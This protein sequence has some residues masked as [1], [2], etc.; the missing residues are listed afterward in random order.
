MESTCPG[1]AVLDR[2]GRD[3]RTKGHW[4]GWGQ[5]SSGKPGGN[6]QL[7]R[8][9]GQQARGPANPERPEAPTGP[10]VEDQ[11]ATLIQCAFRQHLARKELARRQLKRQEY[12]EQMEK[13]QREAYLASVRHEQEVARRRR[14][15]EEAAQRERLEELQ[16]RRRLLDAAFDGDLAEIRA[17]LNEVEQ[18]L[19][20]DGVGHDEAGRS[21]RLQRR[22]AMVECEDSHGN[23]PLSEAAAGGQ[24]LA[25]QLLAELGA[26][27]NSK[28]ASLN[29]VASVLQSWD[30]S[31]TE[32]MLQNMEAE[33]QRR[34]Q[35]AQQQQAAEAKRLALKVQ[36]LARE[37]QQCH[38]V[39]QQAYCELHRRISEHDR[40][41]QKCPD[42][43]ELTLQ[44]IKDTETHVDKL[45][46]EAQ[47]AEEM[48]AMARLEL[49]E[50]SKEEEEEAPGL[51]CQVT[52]L[53]DVL[54][55]DVGNRISADGRWPLVI[56]PSGQAAT[57]L[58]YQD[59]NYLDTMNPE[60]LR[61]ETIRLALLGALRYGKPLVF[62]FRDMDLFPVV[63]RQLD[64][65]QPGLAQALLSRGLLEQERCS[66]RRPSSCKR[67]SLCEC[68]CPAEVSSAAPDKAATAS[69]TVH[70]PDP[71]SWTLAH[72]AWQGAPLGKGQRSGASLVGPVQDGQTGIKR[73][74]LYSP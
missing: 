35:E 33:W 71:D 34:A 63:Q 57:F 27:P 13:L 58:R 51:K 10:S 64:A 56:D 18:L 24:P 68:S 48:L 22:V 65:V 55:K 26:S 23:T 73:S 4:S 32:A 21:R 70:S 37:Q 67:C 6:R 3:R 39:L 15:K 72:R 12:L 19:T 49:R 62:D 41:Q 53:H 47:K 59:T 44:A 61:P 38:K 52:E 31:L 74:Q 43:A 20:R 54:M 28:V 11:A 8:K 7:Q 42:K 66:G 14:E 36:Q 50:Q 30:L 9:T 5:L 2:A 46:Q 16:R 25:I 69:L 60:H 45:R 29:A 40:C 17:V 1:N